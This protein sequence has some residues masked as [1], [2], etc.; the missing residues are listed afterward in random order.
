[1]ADRTKSGAG[2]SRLL[3]QHSQVRVRAEV[4]PFDTWD[5]ESMFLRFMGSAGSSQNANLGQQ[6]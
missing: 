3:A 5:G 1:M 2:G 6:P 4:F